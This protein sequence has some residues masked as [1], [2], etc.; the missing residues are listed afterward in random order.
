MITSATAAFAIKNT[1]LAA[2]RVRENVDSTINCGTQ[3]EALTMTPPSLPPPSPNHPHPPTHTNTQE[4]NY[5]SNANVTLR[6]R[7]LVMADKLAE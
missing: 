6:Q 7:K 5:S 3:H 2:Q 1:D 4:V